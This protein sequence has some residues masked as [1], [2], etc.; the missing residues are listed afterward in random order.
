MTKLGARP[1]NADYGCVASLLLG[2]LLRRVTDG[3]ATLWLQTDQPATVTVAAGG[4]STTT[5]TF[6][7]EGVH[8]ALPV[9]SGLA[10]GPTAY[11]VHI[12]GVPVWP[13]PDHPPSVITIPPDD[14]V[15][16]AFGSCR[17][18]KRHPDPDALEA[19]AN[20]A[21]R[22]EAPLPDLL[23]LIGEQI[24]A[25]EV[26]TFA[27]YARL[28]LDTWSV[29]PVRWLL[30]TVPTMMIFDDHEIHDDWNSSAA[31]LTDMRRHPAWEE[32]LRAG[33]M[34]Y[35]VFQHM[36]NLP[37]VAD[38]EHLPD[39]WSYTVDI[40]RTRLIMLD[41]R[42]SRQLDERRMFPQEHWDR[43]AERS[44]VDCDH[45]V[46]AC[47]LPWLLAPAVHHT[48][49][50]MEVLSHRFGG[51]ME[52]LRRKYDLEHWAAVG[53]SFDELAALI[54]T[55]DRPATVSVI[56]GDVH[57]SYLARP[58][59][60][61]G[62]HQITCSPLNHSADPV[63]RVALRLGWWR[64]LAWLAEKAARLAGVP[65]PKLTWHRLT[66]PYFG[67]AIATLTHRGRSASVL[68]EGVRRDGTLRPVARHDLT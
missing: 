37:P 16:I 32:H 24:Y 21:M 19:Y 15:T 62:V 58:S 64:P 66:K 43:L 14:E 28:Y 8:L 47:S 2:P 4:V 7:V 23:A 25:D 61:P 6:T 40:G 11:T 27:E 42:G 31:W 51:A 22:G 20:R 45:L 12:D 53:H 26:W 1:S 39:D 54:Q 36:G 10:S 59:G 17:E 55:V 68:L 44:Q 52:W 38:P 65:A 3:Q 48:E 41:C 50:L 5:S 9:L 46:L 49:A 30:S 56:G 35:W 34:S 29:P 57:H 33:L 63:M 18:R 60:R 67:N 13:L